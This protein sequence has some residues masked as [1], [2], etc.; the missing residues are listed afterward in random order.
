[1]AALQVSFRTLERLTT[2]EL[3]SFQLLDATDESPVSL[4]ICTTRIK[5]LKSE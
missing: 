5:N 1:M 3:V 4:S 2:D